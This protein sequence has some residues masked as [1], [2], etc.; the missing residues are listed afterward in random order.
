MTEQEL[1]ERFDI[2]GLRNLLSAIGVS[3]DIHEWIFEKKRVLGE[4]F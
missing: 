3:K 4:R 1:R 2:P